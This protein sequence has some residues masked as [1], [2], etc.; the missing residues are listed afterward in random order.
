MRLLA[1]VQG[2]DVGL[3]LCV[4]SRRVS[5]AIAHVGSFAR[6]CPLVI[7]FGLVRGKRL[8]TAFVTA[9]VRAV[10]SMAEEMA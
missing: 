4:R 2:T 9:G 8:L 10:A 7:I 6:V 5:A 1:L 3:Q